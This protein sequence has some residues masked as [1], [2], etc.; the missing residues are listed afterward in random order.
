MAITTRDQLIAAL[1]NSRHVLFD[2]AS[3]SNAVAGRFYSL[4]RATGQPGQGAI[5]A[6]P[7]VCSHGLLGA[8]NHLPEGSS[9]PHYLAWVDVATSL[10]TATLEIHDR[11]CHQGGLVGNAATLQTT[12]LPL[13]LAGVAAERI[14]PEDFS[15]LQWWLE[16]YADTGST[17]VTAT[18]TVV[19]D[20]DSTQT[21]AVP[22]VATSRASG[23]YQILPPQG[24]KGI[25]A[26]N[27]VQLSA[28]SG[29]AG[30]FGVT[31][32][33]Y[34]AGFFTVV[35]N[36]A[37]MYDWAALGLPQIT[38]DACLAL[39][40]LCSTTTTGSSKGVARFVAG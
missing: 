18:V 5:P 34:R 40:Q 28:S 24:K 20:D 7:A 25:K 21:V 9:L 4:W 26:V 14:G 38:S 30:N 27:S 12:N 37:E 17:A 6:A 31:C 29:T 36:K 32:T 13:S 35:A 10:A 3:L 15:Q 16:W 8:L 11:L 23:L 39:I 33:R 1:A 19:C 22:L 2:K